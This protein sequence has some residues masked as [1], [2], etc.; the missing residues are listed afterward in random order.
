MERSTYIFSVLKRH[1][2]ALQ[3]SYSWLRQKETKLKWD[4]AG[5][6]WDMHMMLQKARGEDGGTTQDTF[7]SDWP[8]VAAERARWK[9]EGQVFVQQWDTINPD[10]RSTNEEFSTSEM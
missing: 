9:S 7:W 3:N 4:S 8:K 2:A 5:S 10:V 1:H 6:I